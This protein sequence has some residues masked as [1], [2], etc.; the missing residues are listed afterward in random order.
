MTY[1]AWADSNL[2]YYCPKGWQ[3]LYESRKNE[4]NTMIKGM[5]RVKTAAKRALRSRNA[6]RMRKKWMRTEG[7]YTAPRMWLSGGAYLGTKGNQNVRTLEAY[8]DLWWSRD[9]VEWFQV[10]RVQSG[11]DSGYDGDRSKG[12]TGAPRATTLESSCEAYSTEVDEE[13]I[14]LGKYGHTTIPFRPIDS[15]VPSLFFIGGDTVDGGATVS[16]VFQSANGIFCDIWNP[17]RY[18]LMGGYMWQTSPSADYNEGV[19]ET[20]SGHG[21]CGQ[22]LPV[23]RYRGSA[24]YTHQRTGKGKTRLYESAADKRTVWQEGCLCDKGFAG[25]YCEGQ[26]PDEVAGAGTTAV[27]VLCIGVVLVF[28]VWTT[29]LS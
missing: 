3:G 12:R 4:M 26:D 19:F 1:A 15:D 8:V 13:K 10:S 29:F 28:S 27:H 14:F 17:H 21:T 7:M 2:A 23:D 16:D 25:E 24:F 11:D 18:D 6:M 20:C 9:G 22:I 5:G